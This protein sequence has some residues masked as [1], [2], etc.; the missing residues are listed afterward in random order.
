MGPWR[1]GKWYRPLA[2]LAVMGCLGLIVIGVQPPNEI[3]VP[4]LAWTVGL[5]IVAWFAFERKRFQGPPQIS[6]NKL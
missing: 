5:M 6:G 3:A 2:V 4:I 1:L